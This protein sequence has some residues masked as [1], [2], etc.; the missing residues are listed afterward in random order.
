MIWALNVV[1]A[2]WWGEINRKNT[3]HHILEFLLLRV[4]RQGPH[5]KVN[6][7]SK[8]RF[9]TS[10][11]WPLT[12]DLDLLTWPR[13]LE[14]KIQVSMSVRSLRRA[15]QTH[16]HTNDVKTVTPD[17]LQTWGV[18]MILEVWVMDKITMPVQSDS[19]IHSSSV[20]PDVRSSGDHTDGADSDESCSEDSHQQYM[21]FQ[22]RKCFSVAFHLKDAICHFERVSAQYN[23]IFA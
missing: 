1:N 14:A 16:R 22:V 7:M 21:D 11:P 12:Y 18:K 9:L 13:C 3:T 20:C 8:W 15:R 23:N 10:W 2:I 4:H 5:I 19:Q 6:R 17:L